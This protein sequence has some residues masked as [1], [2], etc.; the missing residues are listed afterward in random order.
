METSSER[1]RMVNPRKAYPADTGLIPVF[2]RS[3]KQNL[4]H[5]LECAVLLELERRRATATY[6]KTKSG[7]EVD[8]LARSPSGDLELVQV[9]VDAS[10]PKTAERETRALV[11]TAEQFPGAVKTLLV[12]AR[13]GIPAQVPLG[14]RV[15]CAWEWMLGR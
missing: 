1:Q 13:D 8:F 12:M 6:V 11:E 3:G 2:D 14:I 10:H 4:G 7:F 15:Q 9:C 5:A